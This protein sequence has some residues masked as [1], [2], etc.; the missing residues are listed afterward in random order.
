[1]HSPKLL[2]KQVH[3]GVRRDAAVVPQLGF[4]LLNS[5]ARL[6]QSHGRLA[7]DVAIV[8][9]IIG[10]VGTEHLLHL[11]CCSE[12]TRR[13]LEVQQQLELDARAAC[14]D[15]HLRDRAGRVS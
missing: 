2:D 13:V 14:E 7:E 9:P 11:G 1:L 4:Q 8:L 3:I 6:I 10:Q 15:L 5:L 12:R